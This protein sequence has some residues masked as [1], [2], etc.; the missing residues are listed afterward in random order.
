MLCE[1]HAMRPG[2]GGGATREGEFEFS[3]GMDGLPASPAARKD[4]D[5]RARRRQTQ[6]IDL[7]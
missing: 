3:P 1:R 4:P 7:R 5:A 2:G 6:F